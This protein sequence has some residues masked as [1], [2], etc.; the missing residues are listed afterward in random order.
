MLPFSTPAEGAR[1][2][3]GSVVSGPA[4]GG[5]LVLKDQHFAPAVT[6]S[7]GRYS[8]VRIIDSSGIKFDRVTFAA[9]NDSGKQPLVYLQNSS[10]VTITNSKL[11]GNNQVNGINLRTVGR[12]TLENSELTN[13]LNGLR[14]VNVKDVKVLAN[15]FSDI[16]ID[17][18]GLGGA[19]RVEISQNTFN[20]HD[21]LRAGHPDAIQFWDTREVASSDI[22][23]RQNSI[24]VQAQGIFVKSEGH[25]G[26]DRVSILENDVQTAYAN[27][28]IL[29]GA[30]DSRVEGNSVRTTK[31]HINMAKIGAL[32]N[33]RLRISNNRVCKFFEKDNV[34]LVL[35]KMQL[36]WSCP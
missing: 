27:A 13:L 14:G 12:F 32:G 2:K 36:G 23:I 9:T 35:E 30:R 24:N 26:F 34:D 25:G 31:Q 21:T 1:F 20:S 18:V 7:G 5:N 11:I 22:K 15:R 4:N 8:S 3:A 29:R 28:I 6:I 17:G 10:N 33:Q 16:S 19:S